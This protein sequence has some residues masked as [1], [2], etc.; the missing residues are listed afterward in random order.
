MKDWQFAG[1][2]FCGIMNAESKVLLTFFAGEYNY[3]DDF[4]GCICIFL[5]AF[6]TA[7]SGGGVDHF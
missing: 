3:E 4:S 1:G 5:F 6:G 7:G 2:A